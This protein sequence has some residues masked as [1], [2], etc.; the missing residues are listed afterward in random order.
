MNADRLQVWKICPAHT[1]DFTSV[2][3]ISK[4]ATEALYTYSENRFARLV[5][6]KVDTNRDTVL[7]KGNSPVCA[8]KVLTLCGWWPKK[9]DEE[10]E[11]N[12]RLKGCPGK[13]H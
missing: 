2:P 9:Y 11:A 6:Y 12:Q 1:V 4:M 8:G 13:V 10:K 5:E 3:H 7:E